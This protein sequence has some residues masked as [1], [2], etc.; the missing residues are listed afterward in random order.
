MVLDILTVL[1]PFLGLHLL[2]RLIGG[3]RRDVL[4]GPYVSE[5]KTRDDFDH[6]E[7][8]MPSFSVTTWTCVSGPPRLG[9]N[10]L[11]NYPFFPPNAFQ[12]RNA[13]FAVSALRR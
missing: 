2:L 12:S 1:F 11:A 3:R 5:T 6:A 10:H 8:S 9:I 7:S 13:L 4:Y